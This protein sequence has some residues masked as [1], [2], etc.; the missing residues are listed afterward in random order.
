MTLTIKGGSDQSGC[1]PVFRTRYD[2]TVDRDQLKNFILFGVVPLILTD[3]NN[4][5]LWL[6]EKF[7]SATYFSPFDITRLK[8]EASFTRQIFEKLKAVD[9]RLVS[10]DHKGQKYQVKIRMLAVMVDGKGLIALTNMKVGSTSCSICLSKPSEMLGN[11]EDY[12]QKTI[13]SFLENGFAPMHTGLH[14]MEAVLHVGKKERLGGKFLSYKTPDKAKENA[15]FKKMLD[16]LYALDSN[17][18]IN[19]AI[20]GSSFNQ[21]TGNTSRRFFSELKLSEKADIVKWPVERLR[22]LGDLLVAVK[23][24]FCLNPDEYDKSGKDLFDWWKKKWGKYKIYI[25]F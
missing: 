11:F 14:N 24:Q 12:K 16:E 7:N 5:N 22:Q 3:Q 25:G 6:N 23:A 10:V 13:H 4:N 2:E 9:S 1:H 21:N 15:E 18:T 20:T 17:L 19:Q 8:E